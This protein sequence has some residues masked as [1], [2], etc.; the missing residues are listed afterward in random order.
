M[1]APAPS[2]LSATWDL[3]YA[4]QL[5]CGYC[6][7][8]SGRRA[9]TQLPPADLLRIAET[10]AAMGLSFVQ[11]SGGEPLLIKELPE[12]VR[13]LKA[14]RVR[15]LLFTNGLLVNDQNAPEL[16]RLFTSIHVSL[17]AAT[18]ELNDRI[19]GRKGAFDGALAAL[20][21]LDREAAA[22]RQ[23]GHR[24]LK[25]GT[26]TVLVRSNFEQIDA[27]RGLALRFPEMSLMRFGVAVPAGPANARDYAEKELLSAEQLRTFRDP[28]FEAHLRALLPEHVRNLIVTDNFKLTADPERVARGEASENLLHIEADGRVRSMNVYE[29]TV[30]NILHDAPPILWQRVLEQRRHPVALKVLSSIDTL[31][32]WAV[33]ARQI[34][35]E[36]ASDEGRTRILRRAEAGQ[37]G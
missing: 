32:D 15:V 34:D 7:S 11:L 17:D 33:A 20:A 27:M 3:T 16:A 35:W 2:P 6:Y 19:R 4:C 37:K 9:A 23:G 5:R 12:I 25:F 18:A 21:A 14:G 13:R 28:A 26:D 10:L 8:E 29:G 31:Q 30:G 1:S 36:F 24:R 22:R